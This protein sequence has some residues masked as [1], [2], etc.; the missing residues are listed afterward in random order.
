MVAALSI[1]APATPVAT[2][3]AAGH[4]SR[5]LATANPI[6]A[7][8][9]S[10]KQ[11]LGIADS[12][13]LQL[14]RQHRQ[15]AAQQ[16]PHDQQDQRHLNQRKTSAVL[17]S[18]PCCPLMSLASQ[19]QI[20]HRHTLLARARPKPARKSKEHAVHHRIQSYA[21][22]NGRYLDS[23]IHVRGDIAAI[24]AVDPGRDTD[25]VVGRRMSR[26]IAYG[27]R[28]IA[29]AVNFNA[30]VVCQWRRFLKLVGR[31]VAASCSGTVAGGADGRTRGLM[32]RDRG[33]H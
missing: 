7:S 29:A 22:L 24:L 3:P 19:H 33:S 32:A 12:A 20:A 25:I 27:A 6:N 8:L 13:L 28:G 17:A 4:G 26:R 21:A 2:L 10:S 5:P 11:V 31:R 18:H 30:L 15:A 1:P 9:A 23:P 16:Q 14:R